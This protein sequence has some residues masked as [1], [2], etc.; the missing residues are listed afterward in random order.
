MTFRKAFSA[1][2]AT[3]PTGVII[4]IVCGAVV[5]CA[6]IIIVAVVKKKK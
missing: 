4:G 3:V 6:A 2:L 5:L 1:V